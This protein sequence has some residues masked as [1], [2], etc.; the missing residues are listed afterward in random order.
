MLLARKGF[1]I[2][3]TSVTVGPRDHRVVG[4]RLAYRPELPYHRGVARLVSRTIHPGIRA[5]AEA[6]T[7]CL[8]LRRA[9]LRAA[10]PRASAVAIRRKL[11]A[12]LM[13]HRESGDRHYAR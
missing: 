13:K 12:E 10:Y 11:A 6:T 9:A 5:W 3:E 2:R 8:A 7:A 4:A 1:A